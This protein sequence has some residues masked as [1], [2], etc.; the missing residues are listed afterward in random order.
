MDQNP[1]SQFHSSTPNQ[2]LLEEDLAL[3]DED[4]LSENMEQPSHTGAARSPGKNLSQG[5]STTQGEDDIQNKSSSSQTLTLKEQELGIT[6]EDA[7]FLPEGQKEW[8]IADI[9]NFS[10][11]GTTVLLKGNGKTLTLANPEKLIEIKESGGRVWIAPLE[12][13]DCPNLMSVLGT[14]SRPSK[15]DKFVEKESRDRTWRTLTGF[16]GSKGTFREALGGWAKDPDCRGILVKELPADF[17]DTVEGNKLPKVPTSQAAFKLSGSE[18]S[19][20]KGF[21]EATS[22]TQTYAEFCA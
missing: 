4:P 8:F 9:D 11:K 16:L 15:G 13:R 14:F 22:K 3:S 21:F 6:M 10:R 17:R 2:G 5:L 1:P 7:P 18:G 20:S 12:P 19:F